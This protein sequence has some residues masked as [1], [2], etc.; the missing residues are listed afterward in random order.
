ATPDR[1]TFSPT[2]QPVRRPGRA[3]VRAAPH[4]RA[5]HRALPRVGRRRHQLRHRHGGQGARA[6]PRGLL[7]LPRQ[8][9]RR[10]RQHHRL[11]RPAAGRRGCRVGGLPGRHRP[12]AAGRPGPAGSRPPARV[13]RR[14]GRGARG[15]RRL[16]RPRPGGAVGGGV[17]PRRDPRGRARG[18]D[19][20]GRRV[21]PDQLHCLPQLRGLRWSPAGRQV[22][23]HA[24]GGRA[25]A[26]LRGHA[27]RAAADAGLLRRGAQARGEAADHR[28]PPEPRGVPGVRRS[29]AGVLRSGLRGHGGLGVRHRGLRGLRRLDRVA[30]RP[31]DTEGGQGV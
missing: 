28:L 29:A 23:A 30:H 10:G 1:S 24:A 8:E 19:R 13:H 25:Q 31:I 21:L 14:G 27:H 15:V 7:H 16:P 18:G 26:R 4:R 22:R 6:L 5:V 17:L 20:P 12:D 2:A 3:D 11:V 9:R